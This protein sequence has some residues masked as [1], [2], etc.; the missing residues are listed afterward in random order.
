ME[1]PIAL[2]V[3]ALLAGPVLGI[4]ALVAVRRIENELARSSLQQLTSRLFLLEQQ[5]KSVEKSIL[6]TREMPRPG[7]TEPPAYPAQPVLRVQN[8]TDSTTNPPP[9]VPVPAATDSRGQAGGSAL[10]L[11]NLGLQPIPAAVKARTED[12]E[13][14]IGGKWFSRIGIVALLI[15]VSYFLKLAFDNNWIGPSGRVAIGVLAG[16]LMLPWS[17]WLLGRGY[18]YFSE[19]IAALGEATLFLS[20]WAGCQYYTLYSRDVGFAAMIAITAV[21]AAVAIGRNSQRIAVLSLLGGL[22]TPILASSGRNEQVV[23][24][25]YLLLL[26]AGS[27]F[28]AAKK[29]WQSLV[30]IAFIGTQ[31]YFWGWYGEFFHS[32]SPLERTVAFATLFFLLYYVLPVVKAMRGESPGRP[33]VAMILLNAFA[34][35]GTLF[36]LLWPDNRWPLTLLFL[37]LAAGLVAVAR[38]IPAPA[39]G[40]PATV[41]LLFAGLAL[42][43]LTLAIPVRLE[44][45]W[46]TLSFAVEGAVLVW[47]GFRVTSSFLRQSGYLLLAISG[48]RLLFLPPDGGQFLFNARFGAYMVMVACFA[49]ALW[50]A[51]SHPSAVGEQEHLEVGIF[52]VAIN[53]YS[54]IA[55]SGEFWDYFGRT[56]TRIDAVLAQ[57]LALSILWTAFASGLLVLGV[58]NKSAL[59]RWQGLGLFGLVVGK[60]FLYDLSFLERAYRIFSFFVLGAVLMS[61]SFLYERK[62]R[63]ERESS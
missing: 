54:L 27:L 62:L 45:K 4:L 47:T 25:T 35:S 13:S 63:R 23:L 2:A 6:E 31:I 17:Q 43:F 61:V 36:I 30:P 7:S 12:L 57:H 20:V 50:A 16:A 29:G 42:T 24:F 46:I 48:L 40:Q 51:K 55:L 28:V 9:P 32:N 59:L 41:R 3:L 37:A 19:G 18:S 33:D 58:Q 22:L 15:S 26:G 1:P 5:V 52:A 49:V 34:Y 60:V 39:D 14:R 10:N 38:L 56:S 53:I 21:M 8:P 11:P 44:G